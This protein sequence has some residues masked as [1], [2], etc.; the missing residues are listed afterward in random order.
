MPASHRR[1]VRAAGALILL[2]PVLLLIPGPT[3]GQDE[4][5]PPSPFNLGPK[6][7]AGARFTMM[8]RVNQPK[9]VDDFAQLQSTYGQLRPRDIFVVNTR[10]K[11]SSPAIQHEIL[12]RLAES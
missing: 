11:G 7:G 12:A 10:W 9:N 8:L 4:S 2:I 3:H 5:C 1:L 6:G